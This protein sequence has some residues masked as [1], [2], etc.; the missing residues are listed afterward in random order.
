MRKALI[1]SLSL[2]L[3]ALVATVARSQ[4]QK[5]AASDA[6][7][8]AA[9]DQP[10]QAAMMAE[11]ARIATP[12]PQQAALAKYAGDFN[13]D[14]Q[15]WMAPGAPP[16]KSTGKQKNEMALGGRYLIGNFDGEFMGKPFHGMSCTGYDVGKQKWF[17]AW[18]DDMS[19]G[20]MAAE[21][22]GDDAGKNI[23]VTCQSYCP[24]TKGMMNVRQVM[25]LVDENTMTTEMYMPGPDGKEMKGME[26]KYT[27][28][29]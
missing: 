28:A 10:D 19:T 4:D 22:T 8:A 6:K 25:H 18:I 13:A 20:M 12:G 3:A 7:T 21:G 16:M 27:R 29:K 23:T 26:I 24:Q 1:V 9:S 11:M 14:V 5:P 17:T 2:A 15:M